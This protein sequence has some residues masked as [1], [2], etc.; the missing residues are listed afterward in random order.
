M[1]S[2]VHST[3]ASLAPSSESVSTAEFNRYL[4]PHCYSKK[5]TL[6]RSYSTKNNG[7]RQLYCCQDCERYFSETYGSPIAGMNTSLSE[8]CQVLKARTSGM[9]LNR[10]AHV[11]GISKNTIIDW[12]KRLGQLKQPLFLYG[13]V[14]NFLQLIIESDELYTRVEKNKPPSES[15]GWTIVLMERAT[16]FIWTLE[17]GEKQRKLFLEAVVILVEIFDQSEV[18]R[19][20]YRWRT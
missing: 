10:T 16:I 4:C 6:K 8:F 20:I 15:S 18:A 7:D 19:F 2:L 17:C 9:G 3:E 1:V 12:E 13:L 5:V 11:F 14:H